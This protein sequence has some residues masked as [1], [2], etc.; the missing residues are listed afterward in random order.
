MEEF[1]KIGAEYEFIDSLCSTLFD[2]KEKYYNLLKAQALVMIAEDNVKICE[3]YLKIAK[4]SPDKATATV[5]LCK[6]QFELAYQKTLLKN[7][8]VD[9]SNAMF[10]ENSPNY[11][12]INT[13]TFAYNH[14]YGYTN[15]TIPPKFTAQAL[16]F[17]KNKAIEIAYENS[18][19]LRVLEST[20]S[21]MEQALKYVKRT[22]FPELSAGV[23]YG[24][25]NSTEAS[26]NNLHHSRNAPLCQPPSVNKV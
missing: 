21:A 17:D 9:L 10:I 3:K 19:D 12:I 25:V 6:A 22:Y 16:G 20:K 23:G 13:K 18:P 4:G 26:N 15:Q 7:A 2:V 14:D 1:Y 5:N 8:K 24:Y 11:N